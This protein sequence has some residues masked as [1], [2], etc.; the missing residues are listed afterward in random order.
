[1]TR[2]IAV[3]AGLPADVIRTVAREAEALGYD[4][5]WVNH[6]PATDGLA[7]LA[8]AARETRRVDLGVGVIPLQSRGPQSI[9]DGVRSN[10]LPPDRLL[11]GVGSA[12]P[13]A[14]RRMRDGI[15]ELRGALSS[16]LVAAALGPEMCRLAGELADG[17]LLN[18]LTPAHARRSAEWVRAGAAK[19]RRPTPR[20]AAY[21]RV[22]IGGAARQ[23]LA[24]E[25]A[26]YGAIPAYAASFE[27]MGARPIETG[28]TVDAPDGVP[29]ALAAWDG[30]V[31]DVVIRVIPA[32][33]SADDHLTVVR[34]ARPGRT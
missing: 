24:G 15:R 21:V 27:R 12:N 13:G 2:G 33:D 18:W 7:A 11:L 19:A 22:A 6:P 16:R 26:R 8:A 32:S 4:S 5:F 14:L 34:A 30:A 10:A 20:L 28:I 29:A 25:A 23:R 9:A 3:F 17:V 31:D 1:M